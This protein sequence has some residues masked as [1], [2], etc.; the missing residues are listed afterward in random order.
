LRWYFDIR[1]DKPKDF[2][3]RGLCSGVHLDGT[4]PLS[5]NK[6]I[7]R[8]HSKFASAIGTSTIGDNDFGSR[9]SLAQMGKKPQYQRRF[10]ENRNNDRKLHL[11]YS[12]GEPIHPLPNFPGKESYR[13]KMV[14]WRVCWMNRV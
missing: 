11:S 12:I 6:P 4:T 7:A 13:N 10:V 3:V 9:R 5:V 2:P 1:M 14:A 8:T